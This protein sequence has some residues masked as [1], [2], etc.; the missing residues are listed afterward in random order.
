MSWCTIESDPGVF[1]E[2]V[3]KIG[4]K[5]VQFEELYTLDEESL[6]NCKPLYGLVFLF[7]YKNEGKR[8]TLAAGQY[9][10]SLFFAKQVISNA[11]AT[12]AILSILLNQS[13]KIDNGEE[14]KRLNEFSVGMTD[15]MKGEA[16]GNSEIIRTVHNSF[17]R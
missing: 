5:G 13:D 10:E 16:I 15:R 1:T 6:A 9:P 3:S 12:Q 4:V 11:C 8:E 7:K 2:L 14:L 17:A